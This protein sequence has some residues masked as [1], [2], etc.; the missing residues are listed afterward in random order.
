MWL[1]AWG[2]FPKVQVSHQI[3]Q[4]LCYLW[5]IILL[6]NFNHSAMKLLKFWGNKRTTGGIQC[7]MSFLREV[8][9]TSWHQERNKPGL[10]V[11]LE[12]STCK[13]YFTN[14]GHLNTYKVIHMN[15]YCVTEHLRIKTPGE[16]M[17]HVVKDRKNS[18]LPVAILVMAIYPSR[19]KR[20]C[21]WRG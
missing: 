4:A 21:I 19:N 5:S 2:Y 18:R 7:Q 6:H 14:H 16:G 8:L 9:N 10:Y 1:K 13:K 12:C 11:I 17:N 20:S 15:V 3:W